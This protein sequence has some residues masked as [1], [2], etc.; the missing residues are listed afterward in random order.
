MIKYLFIL[1][2]FSSQQLFA[3]DREEI[4]DYQSD[5][6]VQL[7]GSLEV[8]ETITVRSLQQE[9]QRGIFR[10][11][12]TIYRDNYGNRVKVGFTVREI[13]KDGQPE[14]YEVLTE[15][16]FQIIRIGN[17]DVFL[18]SGTYTYTI[19]YTTNRQIGFF[20]EFDELYWNVI[21]DS[22]AFPIL[23]AQARITLPDEATILQ[24][25]GYSGPTG[26]STC[27]CE[28][29]KTGN[30]T[31]SITLTKPLNAREA[32]TVA[33]AWPKGVVQEPNRAQQKLIFLGDN[34]GI[35][36]ALIGLLF[37]LAYYLFAWKKVG[38]DPKRGGIYPLFDAP[39]GLDAPAIRYIHKMGFDQTSFTVAMIQLATKGVIKIVEEKRKFYLQ[40]QKMEEEADLETFEK[41]IIRALF[42]DGTTVVHLTQKEYKK[43]GGALKA[44]QEH[45]KV[46]YKGRYFKLN[47]I[48]LVPGILLSLATIIL[49]FVVTF[50]MRFEDEKVFLIMG[51]I[52][53]VFL[54]GI[55]STLIINIYHIA[56]GESVKIGT[57]V[58]NVFSLLFVLVLPGFFI[59][60]FGATFEYG[61][62]ILFMA[63]ALSNYLF[64]YL[65]KAPTPEGRKVFDEIE[66]FRM[67]LNAAEKPMIQQM[68]PPGLTP[69][70]FEKN[71]PYAM[72][73]GVGDAW[74]KSFEN[75][76][77]T[78]EESSKTRSRYQPAWYSGA[79][80][81]AGAIS[82]LSNGL[83][84]TFGN[85]LNNSS[86][87]PGSKSGSGGG[88]RSGGGGGGGGGGGW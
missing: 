56:S 47:Q 3:Q 81:N 70:V 18:G 49:T 87:P 78:F 53:T 1:L 11:F 17:P 16:D 59:Y 29:E 68:N 57:I 5:I 24:Y 41:A 19:S 63:L 84:K 58:S 73:L 52:V 66:G 8:T 10:S 65:M 42:P 48:W 62:L 30:N 28:L 85:A 4:L 82:G 34:A 55:L 27:N 88:G 2:L 60:Q 20:E 72:A 26:S 37:V 86:A 21:G 9:I 33:V 38:V 50:P 45:L 31:L 22:W 32:L 7:N 80:F 74:G 75:S 67:Y 25:A 51:T 71:L 76:L 54:S 69:E 14:P 12:P 46:N 15:G 40:L 64:F 79:A 43:I 77:K 35:L 6:K 13:L 36:V 44:V 61:I 23:R 39:R 83:G